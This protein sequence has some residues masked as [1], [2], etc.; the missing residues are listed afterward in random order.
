MQLDEQRIAEI[1]E[2]VMARLGGNVGGPA[3]NP[4]PGVSAGAHMTGAGPGASRIPRG[5][6]GVYQDAE[7]AVKA[8]RRGFEENERAPIA[9]RAK[10]I[11]AM[12]AVT[13]KHLRELAQY[14]VEETGLGRYEDKLGKN[15]LVMEKTPG[16]EIL[17][18][19]AFTGDDGLM[20]T[21]RAPY[22][23]ILS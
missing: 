21:E 19:V 13:E 5:T 18:S 7:A 3:A 2:R 6:N 4:P 16:V 15:R 20:L 12:R 17:R 10:M 23:V 22:G 9:T 14:A 8:A 1:V 11:A